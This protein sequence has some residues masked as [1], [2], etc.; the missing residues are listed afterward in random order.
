VQ[1]MLDHPSSQLQLKSASPLQRCGLFEAR[2]FR[3]QLFSAK[4]SLDTSWRLLWMVCFSKFGATFVYDDFFQGT[5]FV[6]TE[7]VGLW[8]G[9]LAVFRCPSI[10]LKT[11][12]HILFTHSQEL[13]NLAPFILDDG[14]I[15][16]GKLQKPS[17]F[18]R[19]QTHR[20]D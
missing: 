6:L 7:T 19:R 12:R 14:S 10:E 2:E 9:C 15:V 17:R 16:T 5:C 13:V 8:N 11:V 3:F 4:I 20:R 1:T 18:T